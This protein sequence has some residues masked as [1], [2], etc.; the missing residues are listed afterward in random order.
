MKALKRLLYSY[1]IILMIC[2][3]A[4]SFFI[5]RYVLNAMTGEIKDNQM[6]RLASVSAKMDSYMMELFSVANS[7]NM[8]WSLKPFTLKSNPYSET[9]V[10]SELKKYL[11]ALSYVSEL[12]YYIREDAYIYTSQGKILKENFLNTAGGGNRFRFNKLSNEEFFEYL[13]GC[14]EPLTLSVSDLSHKDG[15][16]SYCM[17]IL[18]VNTSSN[19]PYATVFY[20]LNLSALEQ[21]FSG[22]LDEPGTVSAV[23][24][25]N[26][27]SFIAFGFDAFDGEQNTQIDGFVRDLGGDGTRLCDLFDREYL[28]TCK[29]MSSSGWTYVI[30]TD[31]QESF[32]PVRSLG[33]MSLIF[34]GL[35]FGSGA[36]IIFFL[37]RYNYMPIH[38][39]KSQMVSELD[40]DES[41]READ[42]E[43]VT[44]Q[45][46]IFALSDRISTLKHRIERG[47][48]AAR[49][50]VLNRI[51][52]G[53]YETHG[54]L[55][56]AAEDADLELSGDCFLCLQMSVDSAPDTA[57]KK[58]LIKA[59]EAAWAGPCIYSVEGTDKSDVLFILSF[60][61]TDNDQ[62][63]SLIS[64]L[65]DSVQ[66]EYDGRLFFNVGAPVSGIMNINESL[67]TLVRFGDY[68]YLHSEQ[69]IVF[70]DECI[71]S[72][73]VPAD[74][75]EV[76]LLIGSLERALR[77]ADGMEVKLILRK[78]ARTMSDLELPYRWCKW[79]IISLSSVI[80]DVT[81]SMN[82]I[83]DDD[84]TI[85]TDIFAVTESR[86]VQQSFVLL[87]K[88]LDS[89]TERIDE[90]QKRRQDASVQKIFDY[91]DSNCYDYSFSV[92]K[93]EAD[94]GISKYYI[95]RYV[96]TETGM[97]IQNYVSFKRL[98]KTKALLNST[99]MKIAAIALQ[100]G[101]MNASSLIKK[102]R[103]EFGMTPAEYRNSVRPEP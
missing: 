86:S 20:V 35:L 8:N 14:S 61:G 40:G 46:G 72:E 81:R 16:L 6:E 102:F 23:Y 34:G 53:S 44:I 80:L 84:E 75:S 66:A 74:E 97:T 47:Q 32:R 3:L 60:N 50:Y 45:E 85:F 24:G 90:A 13:N 89:L 29:T 62:Y 36:L 77:Q 88:I 49:E 71:F 11:G 101:F 59:A 55:M 93:M 30:A 22:G 70:Y 79:K 9:L 39:V 2:I 96:K 42:D 31:T 48:D 38:R 41:F 37:T 94:L 78:I 26:G 19:L 91:L 82:L 68:R 100:V 4:F 7:I 63:R 12:G 1:F 69:S 92:S 21:T 52:N 17:Y 27:K 76:D 58:G 15:S 56:K 28:M 33:T 18:P 73:Y 65:Y 67:M 98:E 57:K 5:P 25:Q 95:S 83:I 51:L 64:Q 54:D 99:D 87:E 103:L 10:A 43:L